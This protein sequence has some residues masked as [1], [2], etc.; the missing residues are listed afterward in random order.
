MIITEKFVLLNFPRTGS[1]FNRTM[2]KEL[3][4]KRPVSEKIL[5]KLGVKPSFFKELMLPID[6]TK[7]ARLSGR[8]SQ[9]AAYKDIPDGAKGLPVMAAF[10][11]PFD[12]IISGF[13][14]RFWLKNPIAPV[15]EIKAAYPEYPDMTFARYWDYLMVLDKMNVLDG[16]NVE[17][18]VGP[19]TLHF[20]K[21]FFPEPEIILSRLT[22][23]YVD[24]QDYRSE[25]PDITFLNTEALNQ[26]LYAALLK[27]G[28][29]KARLQFILDTS[30]INA[31]TRK[32]DTKWTDY[33]GPELTKEALYQERM[34]FDL[35]PEYRP[36]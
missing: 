30:R 4:A 32:T 16:A 5:N 29:P 27:F 18:D 3:Y 11:N 1:T 23:S 36:S 6:R 25:M 14:Y 9:H 26:D 20:I 34:L 21:F 17:A 19:L 24:N 15:D 2:L 33:F 10:R 22:N 13:E 7:N 35:F 12:R 31:S 28:Y 8:V